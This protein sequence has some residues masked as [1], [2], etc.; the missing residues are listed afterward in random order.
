MRALLSLVAVAGMA[1]AGAATAQGA[2]NPGSRHLVS[3]NASKSEPAK[4]LAVF[5]VN[6][7]DTQLTTHHK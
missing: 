6:S 5:V 7:D 1:L 3:R 2:E 4:L